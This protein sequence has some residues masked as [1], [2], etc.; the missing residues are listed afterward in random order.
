[1]E[2][3]LNRMVVKTGS[4]L[5]TNGRGLD[6]DFIASIAGQVAKVI[7]SG[8]EILIVSSGAI[9]SGRQRIPRFGD[10]TI[11]KQAAAIYGQPI[12][13]AAWIKEFD[14]LGI[15]AGASVYKDEDLLNVRQPLLRALKEG[16][17]IANGN[18]A[19]YDRTSEVQIISNDN[20]KLAGYLARAIDANLLVLLT[21]I[22]DGVL[23]WQGRVIRRLKYNEGRS[24]LQ[25]GISANGIGG[26]E[27][28][29]K[30]AREF[31][32]LGLSNI[33]VIAGGL[34]PNVLSLILEEEEVGT[35]VVYN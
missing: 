18:D 14:K 19:V 7:N 28:K 8:T 21:D 27:S 11:E 4:S 15:A 13:T 31:V 30:V 26:M 5:V 22:E 24:I 25:A 9:A 32:S 17:I 33:A 6:M 1:M 10:D 16:V 12:M 23:D 34:I 29:L 20:D 35:R 3:L 2:K